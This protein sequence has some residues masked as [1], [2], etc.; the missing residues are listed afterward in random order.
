MTT[1]VLAVITDALL[2]L[3]VVGEENAPTAGQAQLGLRTLNRLVDG[4][5]TNRLLQY[6][7]AKATITMTASQSTY[8][9][10]PGGDVDIPR[11]VNFETTGF[12]CTFVDPTTNPAIEYPLYQLT[13]DAYQAIVQKTYESTY[14][15]NYWF[16]PAY[17]EADPQGTLTFWPVP[18][19]G[20][21]Q[22]NVYYAT[23]YGPYA[24][25]DS[26]SMP[27]GYERFF[28]SNLAV[29]LEQYYPAVR[30]SD[31]LRRIAAES[32]GDVERMNLQMTE[33]DVDVAL[34]PVPP[35][36]P[37]FYSGGSPR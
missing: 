19:V 9:V 5:V 23:Q 31:A 6:A 4:W 16:N 18:N 25:T 13:I 27:Q 35:N 21:L 3:G 12:T 1:T 10:G 11:P 2:A 14:P 34:W 30:V 24:I 7:M 26:I 20:Y 8:T 36:A 22:L 32:K 29:E 37:Q 15:Q 33:L 17:S 28:V